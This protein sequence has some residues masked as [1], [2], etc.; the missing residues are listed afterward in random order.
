MAEENK[1][2]VRNKKKRK[3]LKTFLWVTGV[4]FLV[5]MIYGFVRLRPLY[6]E[7]RERIYDILAD[8]DTGSFRRQTN[9]MIYARDGELIGKLGYEHYDYVDI[10]DISHYIQQGYIDVEDKSFKSHHGVDFK[11]TIRA[12]IALVTHRGRITQ[13][14]STITQQVIK[15]NL[16]STERSFERKALEILIAFQLEKEYTKADIM[17]FYC[18]SCYYGNSCYGVEG[19]A[20]YYFGVDAKSVDLAQAAMIVGTSNSPNNYNPV[21]NYELCM[22]KKERVLGQMLKEGSIS[23]QEYAAAV[24]ERPEVHEISDN[25]GSESYESS[26]AVYCAAIKLMEHDGFEFQ[27]TFSSEED[28]DAYQEK[29]S[30]AYNEATSRIR[31]GGFKINTS[32]D[33]NVQEKLQDALDTTLEEQTDLQEDGRYDMQG[34]AICIDNESGQVIAVV[35]G[36]GTDDAFNRAYMAKRQTGSAIKPLLV[37]GPALNEGVVTPSTVYNDSEIDINGYSPKNSDG[38]YLGD[39][40]VREAL[41]RSVNTIAVQIYNNVGTE[42]AMSYL[43]KMKF[44]NMSFGDAYNSALA[45]GAFT[46]GETVSDMARGFAAIANGGVMR[47]STCIFSLI[48]EAD[49]TIYSYSPKDGEKVFSE[50]TAFILTDMMVG[51]FQEEYGSAV[52]IKNEDQCF[53]GKTGTTNENRDAWFA[54]FSRY[55]TA[56]TW[57]GCDMPRSDEHLV[58]N[59]YPAQV[60]SSF[61]NEMH[62]DLER[63]EFEIPDTIILSGADGSEQKPDYKENIYASRPE[64][65]DYTSG[66]LKKK[67]ADNE[68]ERR[69]V[70]EMADAEATVSEFEQYQVA[71]VDEAIAID[72]KF[73]AVMEVI[74]RIEDDLRQADLR[75]RAEYK[76]SLLAGDVKNNWIDAMNAENEAQAQADRIWNEEQAAQSSE[77][78]LQITHDSWVNTVWYYVSALNDRTIYSSSVDT[79]IAGAEE[80]ITHCEGYGEYDD[81]RYELDQASRK[82]RELPT[83]EEVERQRAAAEAAAAA[84]AAQIEASRDPVVGTGPGNVTIR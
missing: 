7:A 37:Y 46:N 79:L 49:G 78:A 59:G 3:I 35:G 81:L 83:E 38:Q 19:A 80:A 69:I 48:S 54:G 55:Y 14:G 43:D 66:E 77:S 61:M 16:L 67:I 75:E 82:A 72:D 29:Y 34:A 27:Y 56:V 2:A 10:S 50:D 36:R 32:Y 44:G 70:Q 45:L 52:S 5:C 39:M 47:E 64:G 73:N 84:A 28:Y 53:A 60:W 20:K 21:A 51:A 58:G 9:T 13:G 76:Y 65:M 41:A 15:N 8:M 18:N 62:E 17:E 4:L 40:T 11:A 12:A 33:Q 68:R 25:I 26:Y 6:I 42:T 30:E 63:K 57:I 24:A 22:Q 23:E 31:S 71:N 1:K 74:G